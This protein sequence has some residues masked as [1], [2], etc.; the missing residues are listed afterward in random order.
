MPIMP[1]LGKRDEGS[2]VQ[3]QPWLHEILS[4]RKRGAGEMAQL[5]RVLVAFAEDPVLVPST[6]MV[7]HSHL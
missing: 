1:A 4:S 7:A 2:G 5:L 3:G 6:Y